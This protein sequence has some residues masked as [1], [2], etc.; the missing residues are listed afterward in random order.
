VVGRI[1]FVTE[2]VQVSAARLWRGHVRTVGARVAR[3]LRPAEAPPWREWSTTIDDSMVGPVR[4]TGKLTP[5]AGARA[6]V[7]MVHGL[8]GSSESGY[9]L[10]AAWAA[11][12][13]GLASLRLNLRGSDRLGEDYYHAGLTADLRAALA[14]PELARFETV[15]LLGYSMGG[16]VALRYGTEGGTEGPGQVDPRVAGI[17][18]VCAPLDLAA[19]GRVL[20]RPGF[21]IYRRYLLAHLMEIYREVA[22]RRPVPMPVEEAARIRRFRDWDDR[23]VAP[24]HGFDS[25]DDYYRRAS[26]GPRLVRL[27]VPALLVSSEDDPMVPAETVRPVLEREGT[28]SQIASRMEVRWVPAA[29]HI[30]F[31]DTVDLGLG[32]EPVPE[33]TGRGAGEEG[34]DDGDS[35]GS[36]LERQLLS[37]LTSRG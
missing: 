3:A 12:E 31:P 37:W 18:A 33:R 23:V 21:W 34:R 35:A 20:D 28:A 14:S 26:V 13:A 4:L 36:R 8:G 15:Y 25:A 30:A 9:L 29:G 32:T 6:V 10:T 7:V 22:A 17:A 2:E 19:T 5:S 11:A 24:R 1:V 16:H 27:S